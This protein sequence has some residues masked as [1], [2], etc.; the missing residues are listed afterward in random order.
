MTRPRFTTTG[1]PRGGKTQ[2]WTE[3][4]RQLV[5]EALKNLCAKLPHRTPKAIVCMMTRIEDENV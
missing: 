4:E 1:R 3:Q 5:R 2:Y